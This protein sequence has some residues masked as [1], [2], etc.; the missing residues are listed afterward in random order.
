MAGGYQTTGETT[1]RGTNVWPNTGGGWMN[2]RG[3]STM[4]ML[5]GYKHIV[6]FF[7][8]F[9]WWKTEP[10]DEL[11]N[12]GVYCLA[13]PGVAYALY[14]PRTSAATVRLSA[15]RYKVQWFNP[16]TGAWIDLPDAIGGR[17]ASPTVPDTSHDWALLLRRVPSGGE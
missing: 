12:A 17:W 11:A 6:D 4:T 8:S 14:L 5:E 13:E 2:G 15:G 9:E 10:H 7:T 1:R 16:I 3:D